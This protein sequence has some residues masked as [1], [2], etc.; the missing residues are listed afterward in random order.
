MKWKHFFQQ[1]TKRD[2]TEFGSNVLIAN[3]S[4]ILVVAANQV[5]SV[6][7]DSTTDFKDWMNE[8]GAANNKIV[9]KPPEHNLIRSRTVASPAE[10]Q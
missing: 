8:L 5:G 3:M 9:L 10:C 6:Q 1:T 4:S 2:S 7:K